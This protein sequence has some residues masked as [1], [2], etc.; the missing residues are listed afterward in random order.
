M[1]DAFD[2]THQEEEEE[3]CVRVRS[4]NRLNCKYRMGQ[5]LNG[6]TLRVTGVDVTGC[7]ITRKKK[8][9]ERKH[10]KNEEE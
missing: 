6:W 8:Q 3:A 10:I 2:Q 4:N 7:V 9:T 5:V 1:I